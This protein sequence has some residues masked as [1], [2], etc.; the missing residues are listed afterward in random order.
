MTRSLMVI[1]T[2]DWESAVVR[3]NAWGR[4]EASVCRSIFSSVHYVFFRV[5]EHRVF[6]PRPWL[7]VHEISG[8]DG[9]GGSGWTKVRRIVG[10]LR[11]ICGLAEHIRP[12]VVQVTDPFLSGAAGL[13][14]RRRYGIPL[15]V[16]LVSH[17]RQS[18]YAAR[19]RPVKG[20]PVPLA[21]FLQDRVLRQADRVNT[22]CLY[23]EGYA[24]ECGAA[25]ER[26]K[27]HPRWVERSFFELTPDT[28]FLGRVGV[29][30]PAPVVYIGRLSPE[31][32]ADDLIRA[33]LRIRERV[34]G[35]QLVV[36]GGEGAL[37]R[38]VETVADEAGAG[39]DVFIVQARPEEVAGAAGC[40]GVVLVPHGGYALL[41]VA[42]T[43]APVVAY[44]FEW[45]PEII[46]PGKT[47]HLVPY[48]NWRAMA[49]AAVE[50]LTTPDRARALASALRR[51]ART[52]Y[53]PDRV[54]ESLNT[55]MG[56]LVEGRTGSHEACAFR[57]RERHHG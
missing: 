32:Y 18:W 15:V 25:P 7:T 19:Q 5:P 36:L 37:R 21:F 48:R 51:E 39:R 41:E 23:Y 14:L 46:R 40:A 54:V 52:N 44:D 50:L 1:S 55:A 47:G 16:N 26:I 24:I 10:G 13:I 42:V 6:H 38:H 27:V 8:G 12:S 43:G 57:S 34:P 33:F 11:E 29:R 35:R 53:H 17:Y 20:L 4:L 30:D 22:D 56:E 49:D 28:S 9:S 31:K 3:R 2:G 45:H